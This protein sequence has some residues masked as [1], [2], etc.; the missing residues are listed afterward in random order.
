MAELL[1]QS[2]EQRK[3]REGGK[4]ESRRERGERQDTAENSL[5]VGGPLAISHPTPT[6]TGESS[7]PSLARRTH[8]STETTT[9][10]SRKRRQIDEK[11]QEIDGAKLRA[12][13]YI[14]RLSSQQ[15]SL[16]PPRRLRQLGRRSRHRS[17]QVDVRFPAALRRSRCRRRSR[18]C[19]SRR[20]RFLQ[21]R[22]GRSG[23]C[24]WP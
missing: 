19:R 7:V 4:F 15:S 5:G 10:T 2:G 13:N 18:C 9:S 11:S 1:D 24:C 17:S 3:R 21:V 23:R 12:P 22:R 6:T 8:S 14:H 20:R 16:L